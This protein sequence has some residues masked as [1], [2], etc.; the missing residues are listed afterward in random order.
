MTTTIG[1][2]NKD[3]GYGFKFSHL[4]KYVGYGNKDVGFNFKFSQRQTE[5]TV[6]L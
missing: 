2:F 5:E 1:N 4:D 6:G 3:L